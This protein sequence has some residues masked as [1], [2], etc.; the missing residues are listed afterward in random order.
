[1]LVGLYIVLGTIISLAVVSVLW[2]LSSK[3]S[4]I[5]CPAWLG[6]MVE[7][8]NPFFNNNR[9]ESII[10][11]SDIGPGMKVLDFGCGPGRVTVPAAI[12]VG[13]D[14]NVTAFDIQSGMLDR[15]RKKAEEKK[16]LNIEYIQGASGEGKLG[17]D[18][19][20]RALMV[21][22]LGEIPD[23]ETAM[24]EIF[25]CLKPGGILSVTEVI[26]DPHFQSRKKVTVVAEKAGFIK[27]DRFGSLMS[28]TNLFEKK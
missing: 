1:M 25:N 19:Y 5:P 9:S 22:V 26:A 23:R 4:S 20:D 7:M 2:R 15:V 14:G 11:N 3:R 10:I 12:A 27:K 17:K 8:E 13:P 21:N 28:Y 24:K 18:Q 6:L 16:I